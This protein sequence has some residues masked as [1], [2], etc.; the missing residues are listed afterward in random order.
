EV[1]VLA[2]WNPQRRLRRHVQRFEPRLRFVLRGADL[3][4]DTAAGAIFGCDLD[5]VLHAAP[6]LVAD[7]GGLEGGRRAFQF[8]RIVNLDPDHSMGA[9]HGTLAALDAGL[10][11]PYRNLECKIALL[12]LC[13]SGGERAVAGEGADR[14]LI[15][16]TFVDRAQHF[17]FKFGRLR[18]EGTWHLDGAGDLL[19]YFHFE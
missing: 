16:P 12:P 11:V 9:N 3:H 19:R 5:A 2:F 1:P 17:A 7:L 10:R 18:R 8:P 14:Q 6:F 15:S 4:A 13:G